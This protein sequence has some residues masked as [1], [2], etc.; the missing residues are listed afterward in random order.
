MRFSSVALLASAFLVPAVASAETAKIRLLESGIVSA[1]DGSVFKLGQP[2]QLT[3]RFIFKNF[4]ILKTDTNLGQYTYQ[5]SVEV[6]G[7]LVAGVHT[8]DGLE[9]ESDV[10][11]YKDGE[12]GTMRTRPGNHKAGKMTVTKEW[13]NTSEW[14]KWRN[15]AV[16]GGFDNPNLDAESF[17]MY[18]SQLQFTHNSETLTAPNGSVTTID[19]QSARVLP[20]VPGPSAAIPFLIGL[21]AKRRRNR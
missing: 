5:F 2:V 19:L 12:D 14:Y 7:V 20:P 11:E 9:S 10:V 18:F 13:S 15:G 3:E 6:E 4:D 17:A 16:K 8:I 1:C 21:F